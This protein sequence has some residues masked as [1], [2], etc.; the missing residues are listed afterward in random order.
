MQIGLTEQQAQQRLAQQGENRLAAAKRKRPLSIFL[1]Q[2]RDVMVLIL[3]AATVIS[4]LLGEITDAV[5]I[6]LIVLLNAVL[7]FVQEYRTERTLEALSAMTAPTARV[8]RDGTLTTRPAAE[9]VNGDVIRV[10]A[11][12]RVPADCRILRCRGLF[13]EESVLTGESVPVGKHP[14]AP[15]DTDNA[16]GKDTLLY[17]GT[18][19]TQ[20]AGEAVVIATGTATQ[21]GQI[22]SMLS[23]IE[24]GRT[25]L[26]ERLGELGKTVA[27]I[28]LAVCLIVF[29]AGVLRGEPVFDMLLTGITIAIAAI[30]EGLPATVTIA[31][32]LAVNRMLRANA[33]VNRLHAVETLGC[34]SVICSDKTGTITE[35]RMTVTRLFA[36]GGVVR[37]AWLRLPDHRRDP[38]WQGDLQPGGKAGSDCPAPVRGAVQQCCHPY[39]SGDPLPAAWFHFRRRR[40]AGTGGSHGNRPAGCRIQGRGHS[41]EPVRLETNGGGAL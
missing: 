19:I 39:R 35:N 3:L 29:G 2:F 21:V 25:P 17:T 5:T 37:G 28:C 23:Q 38:A 11:G 36:G 20:G 10:E 14:G 31:L 16:P 26:Q 12:D 30:P 34:T 7:G 40:L 24:A 15:E 33:L 8:F 1:G 9:L 41:P 22:S 27:I 18:G 32:A 6:I 13:A 4:A